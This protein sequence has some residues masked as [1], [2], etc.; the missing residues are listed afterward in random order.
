MI[1]GR[2]R[3]VLLSGGSLKSSFAARWAAPRGLLRFGVTQVADKASVLL[4]TERILC[5]T[6]GGFNAAFFGVDL[7]S[8]RDSN[9]VGHT[10]VIGSRMLTVWTRQPGAIE[11][12]WQENAL[13]DAFGRILTV[14]PRQQAELALRFTF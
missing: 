2:P 12:G 7:R 9:L 3:P 1:G 5:E 11:A 14:Q 13:S 4:H 10:W 8:P 6:C